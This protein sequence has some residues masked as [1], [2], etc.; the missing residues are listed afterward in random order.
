MDT[1]PAHEKDCHAQDS[2]ARAQ[3]K[4]EPRPKAARS[5]GSDMNDGEV[6]TTKSQERL[7]TI[8]EMANEFGVSI[9]TLRFYEDRG[10]LHPRRV[11]AAR[12]YG[13]R[14]RLYLKMILK[15][16]QLGFTLSEIHD[17]LANRE[18]ALLK[19][20]AA[21]CDLMSPD[22]NDLDFEELNL[23][24]GL[25]P[26]QIVAQIN[27]LERQR[28]ELDEAIIALRNAHRRLLE[29]PCLATAS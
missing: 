17:I 9:R 3:P 5:R 4:R 29:S 21:Q 12:Q 2:L 15:G 26:E 8:R 22:L 14:D 20:N 27:H 16:K 6:R 24:M 19:P 18:G 28:K 1:N 7:S 11:G 10:L 23:E 13:A 25:P